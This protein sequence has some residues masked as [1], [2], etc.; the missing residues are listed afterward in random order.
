MTCISFNPDPTLSTPLY[1]QL[2]N[3]IETAILNGRLKHGDRLPPTR[4]LS[5]DLKVA[6]RTIVKAYDE[7][8]N[9]GYLAGKIGAG[10]TVKLHPVQHLNSQSISAHSED[11]SSGVS[12]DHLSNYGRSLLQG[13][14]A[15]GAGYEFN[16]DFVLPE[17]LPVKQWRQLITRN[18]QSDKLTLLDSGKTDCD[19]RPLQESVREFLAR[20]K[21]VICH[22]EQVVVFPNPQVAIDQLVKIVVD[23]GDRISVEDP[24]S[25]YVRSQL[26]AAGAILDA[27][28]VDDQGLN[29]NSLCLTESAKAAYLTPSCQYP[30]G[31]IL[32]S[33]RRA[34]LLEWA[35][36]NDVLLIEDASSSDFR[37]GSQT[38][39]S[40]QGLS[41]QNTVYIYA[42]HK[43]LYPL[44]SMTVVVV[45]MPMLAALKA[46]RATIRH[47]TDFLES[48]V[49]SDFISCGYLDAHIRRV[50]RIFQERRQLMLYTLATCFWRAVSISPRT[51][52][53]NVLVRFDEAFDQA[54]ISKCAQMADLPLRSTRA[55]YI[56]ADRRNEFLIS[57]AN[58]SHEVLEQRLKH[59]AS[60]IAKEQSYGPGDSMEIDCTPG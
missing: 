6:R 43:M 36:R 21:G 22:P 17:L 56:D 54:T 34:Q 20:T 52:G 23:P 9:K 44:T 28:S 27:H 47:N 38:T 25:Q 37:Y 7:L 39:S 51:S 59:F 31:T 30:T 12:A 48:K 15:D 46:A 5:T 1:K 4:Q 8:L 24:G 53:M 18:C 58:L 50:R 26:L 10:T 13:S 57:F 42:F 16:E 3:S 33:E 29:T 32:P 55:N 11:I 40:I 19:F 41:P 2:S 45:P 49:L 35:R 14:T 60:L